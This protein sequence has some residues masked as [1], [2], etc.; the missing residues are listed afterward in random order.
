MRFRSRF[1]WLDPK[2]F[3]PELTKALRGDAEALVG[4]LQ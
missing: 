2:F 1:D 3:R 4:V